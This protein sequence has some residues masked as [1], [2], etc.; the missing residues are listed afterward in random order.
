MPT[1]SDATIPIPITRSHAEDVMNRLLP[2]IVACGMAE[3]SALELRATAE[4]YRTLAHEGDNP[5]LK[6][7]L[8][9][10][11]DEFLSLRYPL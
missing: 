5:T 6:A 8:L 7:I 3:T 10:V 11:A 9:V 4:R 2:R 1:W